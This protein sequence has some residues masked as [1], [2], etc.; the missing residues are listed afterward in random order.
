MGETQTKTKELAFPK[1]WA[2]V[3]ERILNKEITAKAGYTQL[4]LTKAEYY[5][6]VKQESEQKIDS[7]ESKGINISPAEYFQ[8]LK[9]SKI[10]LEDEELVQSYQTA[11]KL[12]EGYQ[13]AGQE[14]SIRK[15]QFIMETIISEKKLVDLGVDTFV[16]R[17][18]VERFISKV[19]NKVVKVIELRN[20]ER[21][22][23]EEIQEVVAMTKDIF[24][25]LYVVFTDYT[26]KVEKE[27]AKER[28]EKDPI[29]FGV[30]KDSRNHPLSDRMYFLGDWIDDY[31]DLTLES[32]ID[33]MKEKTGETISHLVKTLKTEEDFRNALNNLRSKEEDLEDQKESPDDDGPRMEKKDVRN[34]RVMNPGESVVKKAFKKVRSI[35]KRN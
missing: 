4:G 21:P 12:L 34:F 11:L 14:K 20:Y 10:V 15:L 13:K 1:N 19:E 25:D 24:T 35:L 23:P 26:G 32:L 33:T 17:K 22:I 5:K 3:R 29:L 30:F 7:K 27:V 28:R 18:D 6:L 9:D 8:N 2:A 31:C 16:Y